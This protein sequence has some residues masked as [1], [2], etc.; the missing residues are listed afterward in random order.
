MFGRIVFLLSLG[1]RPIQPPAASADAFAAPGGAPG[2]RPS[3][4]AGRGDLIAALLSLLLVALR[5]SLLGRPARFGLVAL[6]TAFELVSALPSASLAEENRPP[7]LEVGAMPEIF[8][9]WALAPRSTQVPVAG[10]VSAGYDG[11]TGALLHT[12]VQGSLLGR[13]GLQVSVDHSA[14]HS[15]VPSVGLRVLLTKQER[16]GV[17]LSIGIDYR[18]RDF[19]EPEGALIL[20]ALVQRR[21]GRVAL[22]GGTRY[23]QGVIDP[24]ERHLEILSA[25]LYSPY[26]RFHVG[27]D[28]RGRFNLSED[29]SERIREGEADADLTAGPVGLLTLGRFA[30]L[31]QVGTHALWLRGI[32]SVGALA[33]GGIGVAF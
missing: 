24:E 13:A 1:R 31:A 7:A 18:Q 32:A 3:T 21:W 23:G 10:L 30:L 20:S 4:A 25:I 19:A 17:D 27:F 14:A 5:C 9:P 2:P 11:T 33:Q 16:S 26:P 12:E 8:L 28:G 29:W 22:L 15:L 6:V